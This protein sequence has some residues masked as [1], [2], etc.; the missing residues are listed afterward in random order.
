MTVRVPTVVNVI[1]HLPIVVEAEQLSPVLAFTV[2]VPV[3]D[4]TCVEPTTVN[5]MVAG[6][7]GK[8]G[9]GE[10][11]VIVVVVVALLTTRFTVFVTVE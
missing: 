1:E 5:V 7:F 11:E 6:L 4:V 3:G 2:T 8:T 9:F 10:T